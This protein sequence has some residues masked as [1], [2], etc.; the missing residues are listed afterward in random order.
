MNQDEYT[1]SSDEGLGSEPAA[2]ELTQKPVPPLPGSILLAE[3]M[4]R[5]RFPRK[6][7]TLSF[8]FVAV[9]SG[10]SGLLGFLASP[11]S[12]AGP[13]CPSCC[14]PSP[15]CNTTCCNKKCCNGNTAYKCIDNGTTCRG[16]SNT[17][18]GTSCWGCTV[19][20]KTQLC[21]DCLT[22]SQ[23]G[24]KNVNEPGVNRCICTGIVG[25]APQGVMIIRDASEVRVG[26]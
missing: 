7:S 18:S 8:G 9:A 15:C 26:N 11:A 24:C 10:T 23:T 21:C 4:E 12:A 22:D 13:C 17:W 5:S 2:E 25:F 19:N 6:S 14:G 1:A 3:K 20:G 16:Y